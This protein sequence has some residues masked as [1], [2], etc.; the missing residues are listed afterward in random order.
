MSHGRSTVG[1]LMPVEN[2]WRILRASPEIELRWA[3]LDGECGFY[4]PHDD[5]S[6][7]IVLDAEI[8]FAE[9]RATLLHEIVHHER[10]ICGEPRLDERGVEDEVA[11][12]L[13]P[14]DELYALWEIAVLNDLPVEPYMVA[15]RFDVPDDVAERAMRLF[16][17]ERRSA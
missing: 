6:A 7:I 14:F 15:E 13:V 9:R 1:T 12:R 3:Y 17:G 11:R 16:L 2:P 8:G 10:G 5:G 4:E